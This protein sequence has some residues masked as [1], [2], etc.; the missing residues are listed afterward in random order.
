MKCSLTGAVLN[1]ALD[2]LLVYGVEGLIPPMHLKGA[3][4]A[5]LAAQGTMLI[6]ALWFFF[7]K[8]PFNLKLS[9]QPI[10]Q[11]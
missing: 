7:K 10:G 6:M 9:L 4:Y 1:V 11:E 5:S 8:T 3:A 2:Y